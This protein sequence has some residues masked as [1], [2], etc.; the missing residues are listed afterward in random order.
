MSLVAPPL[1]AEQPAF[2][3]K[4][5]NGP[6][7]KK[8]LWMF[9]FF[10]S[11]PTSFMAQQ[12]LGSIS[13]ED[14]HGTTTFHYENSKS[15]LYT[16]QIWW[17]LFSPEISL[18]LS[19]MLNNCPKPTEITACFCIVFIFLDSEFVHILSSMLSGAFTLTPPN[20]EKLDQC[21]HSNFNSNPYLHYNKIIHSMFTRPYS[22]S[23]TWR[24]FGLLKSQSFAQISRHS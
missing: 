23:S 22:L 12:Q 9:Q 14:C 21:F 5:G 4:I 13:M 16:G 18:M 6:E 10:C 1:N 15:Y 7:Q 19:N 3:C 11:P 17:D 20:S 24:P 8:S 2:L